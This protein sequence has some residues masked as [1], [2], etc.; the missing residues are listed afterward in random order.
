MVRMMKLGMVLSSVMLCFG[1]GCTKGSLPTNYW[2]NAFTVASDTVIAGL[3]AAGLALVTAA[4][5]T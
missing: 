2:A 3:A 4:F 1:T 5:G